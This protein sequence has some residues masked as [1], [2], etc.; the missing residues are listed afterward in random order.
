MTPEEKAA[1]IHASAIAAQIEME[2]MKVDNQ[3]DVLNGHAPSYD[4][5]SFAELI[6]KHGIHH[7]AMMEVFND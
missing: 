3:R 6:K 7:N 1:Y 5:A 2:G 4:Y